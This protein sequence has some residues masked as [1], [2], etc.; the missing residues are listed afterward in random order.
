MTRVTM[1]RQVSTDPLGDVY[2][3]AIGC[4]RK[5]QLATTRT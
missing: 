4:H 3:M 2:L 1:T 5:L